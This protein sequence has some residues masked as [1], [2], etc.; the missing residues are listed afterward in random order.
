M[1]E[2]IQLVIA[3][4]KINLLPRGL[5]SSVIHYLGFPLQSPP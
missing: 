2:K 4:E 5:R 1:E 3:I